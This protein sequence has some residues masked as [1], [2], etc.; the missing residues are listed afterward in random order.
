MSL[1]REEVKKVAN[2]A[3]LEISPEEEANFAVQLSSILDYFAQIEELNTD[4]VQPMTR[5]IEVVN[6]TREDKQVTNSE[7]E[8]ILNSAP[9]R[10][11]DF[12]R[13]P[14]IMG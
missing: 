13:V 5:A 11:D 7:R 4:D 6:I 9:E 2:L 1:T 3:R 8:N 10:E 12:F 14:K